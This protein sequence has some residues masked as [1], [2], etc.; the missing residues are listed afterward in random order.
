[1]RR[2]KIL[3]VLGLMFAAT[4]AAAGSAAADDHYVHPSDH[5][6]V[7]GDWHNF[8][9]VDDWRP[10]RGHYWRHHYRP[11]ARYWYPYDAPDNYAYSDNYD[12]HSCAYFRHRWLA[13]GSRYWHRRY[14]WCLED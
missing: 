2:M 11:Y 12:G 1:M 13:T 9:R 6:V 7:R 5:R 3:P 14:N 10:G 4:F 8:H